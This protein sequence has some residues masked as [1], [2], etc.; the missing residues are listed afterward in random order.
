[1]GSEKEKALAKKDILNF[2]K[3][4]SCFDLQFRRDIK[5]KRTNKPVYYAW[6][7]QFIL[8]GKYKNE[9]LF[10]DIQRILNCGCLHFVGEN[11]IRYSVQKVDDLC[12]KVIPFLRKHP[13]SGKKNKDFNCWARAVEII[14]Q[15]KGKA[16]KN[17]RKQDFLQLIEAQKEMQKYKIK[18]T[19]GE[20]WL[21]VAES[22]AETLSGA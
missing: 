7:A 4:Q 8:V 13:L 16:I 15:N 3:N 6:K 12:Q 19:Q 20:K 18:K 21:S 14:F 2:L 5:H 9:D 22:I 10:R 17:W 11:K 1:M